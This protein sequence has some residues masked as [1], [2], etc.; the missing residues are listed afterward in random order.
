MSRSIACENVGDVAAEF[1]FSPKPTADED[2]PGETFPPWLQ[3]KPDHGLLLPGR[4]LLYIFAA[5]YIAFRRGHHSD[6]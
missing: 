5:A 2:Q 4:L 6:P 3:V 1:G